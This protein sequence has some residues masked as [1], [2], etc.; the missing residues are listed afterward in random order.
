MCVVCALS[1]PW[2]TVGFPSSR[3]WHRRRSERR[4]LINSSCLSHRNIGVRDDVIVAPI[5]HP[6]SG[7][8]KL[9]YIR[10]SFRLW[11]HRYNRRPIL[12][13]E[14]ADRPDPAYST[15]RRN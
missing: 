3:K 5:I 4:V 1:L 9:S 6:D 10:P 14:H 12:R 13:V 8:L 15:E 2:V 11:V 7:V